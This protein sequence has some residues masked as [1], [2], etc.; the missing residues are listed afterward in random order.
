MSDDHAPDALAA[1]LTQQ[2]QAFFCGRV[3]GGE[4]QV[5]FGDERDDFHYFRQQFATA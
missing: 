3:T 5:V 1:S 2:H 4:Y